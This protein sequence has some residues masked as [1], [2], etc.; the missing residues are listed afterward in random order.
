MKT[1]SGA[2]EVQ[3]LAEVVRYQNHD[4]VGTWN[5]SAKKQYELIDIFHSHILKEGGLSDNCSLSPYS[6]IVHSADRPNE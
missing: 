1:G 5:I 6:N 2:D 4:K 3:H